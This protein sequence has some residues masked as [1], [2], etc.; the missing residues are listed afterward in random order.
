M[1]GFELFCF[2]LGISTGGLL[3]IFGYM[4]TKRNEVLDGPAPV[5]VDDTKK[6]VA[7]GS[8]VL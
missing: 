1:T 5:S 8:E 2:L 7:L 3:G 4:P 6:P